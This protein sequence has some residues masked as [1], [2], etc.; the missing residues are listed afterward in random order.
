MPYLQEWGEACAYAKECMPPFFYD[1]FREPWSFLLTLAIAS[2]VF[3]LWNERKGL[4]KLK[5]ASKLGLSKEDNNVVRTEKRSED[6]ADDR[7]DHA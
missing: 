4:T 1:L 6:S 3:W 7:R 2:A 5:E